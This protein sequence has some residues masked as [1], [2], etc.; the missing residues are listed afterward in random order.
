MIVCKR[1]KISLKETLIHISR[2][3]KLEGVEWEM[4]FESADYVEKGSTIFDSLIMS[5]C[6]KDSGNS[7]ISSDKIY[8][9]F[10]FKVIGL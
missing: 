8:E 1:E 9:K 6:K 7:I 3:A 4:F 2:I 10:G 5:I